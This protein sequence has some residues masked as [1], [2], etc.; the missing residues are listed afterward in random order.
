MLYVGMSSCLNG[1]GEGVHDAN[2]TCGHV[3]LLEWGGEGVH[4]ANRLQT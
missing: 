4:D 2:V 3:Q 1:G